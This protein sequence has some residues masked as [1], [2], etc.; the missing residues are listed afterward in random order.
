MKR[1]TPN[2]S[3]V[4]PQ[5]QEKI[6]SRAIIIQALLPLGLEYAKNW[7]DEEV[8][9]L[10]G[11]KYVRDSNNDSRRWGCQPGSICLGDSKVKMMVPRVRNITAN[12]EIPLRRYQA[13]QNRQTVDEMALNKVLAGIS[14]RDYKKTVAAVPETF[15]MSGSAV[16]RRYIRTS[17]QKLRA[18][19]ERRLEVYD[20]VSV[21][22]DG[23]RFGDDGIVVALGVTITGTKI[24]LGIVQTA[25]ENHTV[26]VDFL[27][28]LIRRGL[29]P[30][31][32]RL[33]V[34]DGSKGFAKAIKLVF[35]NRAFIQRCQWHKRENVV[36]YLPE[37]Q[38]PHYRRKLQQAYSCTEYQGA[39]A[40][41]LA[42][43]RE[44]NTINLSA[45]KSLAEGLDETL[46]LHRLGLFAKLSTSLKTTNCIESVLS[47]AGRITRRVSRWR[48]SSQKQRWVATALLEIE[49]KLRKIKGSLYLP[50]LRAA[51]QAEIT[52][53]AA[54]AKAA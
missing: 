47:Q 16:S 9:E 13:L 50:Q 34:I 30:D 46:T 26:C 49:P 6:D 17:Q 21:F 54:F 12:A 11:A 42:I 41:L 3:S 20:I 35:G 24:M 18:L 43:Y 7:L 32:E 2:N 52:K 28:D 5:K 37:K 29:S 51:M 15:G 4:N 23:K 10:T 33:F 19:L 14:C 53:K 8:A 39:R 27:K 25:S 31:K 1:I 48:N 22:I 36:K 44:L 40:A 38:R 45:A